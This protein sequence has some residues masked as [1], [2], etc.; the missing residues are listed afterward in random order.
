MTTLTFRHNGQ[1][2]TLTTEA[3][4]SSYGEP[5]LVTPEG[6]QMRGGEIIGEVSEIPGDDFF[7]SV[8]ARPLFAR[9]FVV[10]A[11]DTFEPIAGETIRDERG[12]LTAYGYA[13]A[14]MMSR[15]SA[16]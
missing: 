1:T 6:V 4:Q 16:Q 14:N 11:Q 10:G 7:A 9:E 5:V 3:S 2:Y 13:C 15:F 12:N 8:P